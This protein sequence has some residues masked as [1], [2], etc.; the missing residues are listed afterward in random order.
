MNLENEIPKGT[1]V[2]EDEVVLPGIVDAQVHFRDKSEASKATL[3]SESIAALAG[4]VTSVINNPNQKQDPITTVKDHNE[5]LEKAKKESR[6][7]FSSN[8]LTTGHNLE[9]LLN[10]D[11]RFTP[12]FKSFVTQGSTGGHGT[13]FAAMDGIFA[14]AN[15]LSREMLVIVHSEDD[16]VIIPLEALAKRVYKN[17]E[18]PFWLNASIRNDMACLSSTL[19]VLDSRKRTNGNFH[20]YHVSTGIEC[21]LL[22]HQYSGS[23]KISAET[24]VHY[25]IFNDEAYDKLGAYAKCFPSIKHERDR[26]MLI[27]AVLDDVIS[28]I[29][30]DHAPHLEENK[31]G[32]YFNT[33]GGLPLVQHSLVSMVDLFSEV[34]K[35]DTDLMLSLIERKMARAPAERF[36]MVGRGKLEE[37][38]F[39]DITTLSLNNPWQ[40]S[41]SNILYKC[42][43]SPFEGHTFRAKVNNTFVNGSHSYN[44]GIF[45]HNIRGDL[46]EF[47]RN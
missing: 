2:I 41:K 36:K 24:C 1:I 28:M 34:L 16:E 29:T 31:Q 5:F 44:R 20:L 8:V 40:V 9:E 46:I 13:P 33:F 12:A 25:L 15:Q 38:Y 3:E 22:R 6:I 19:K 17:Q 10:L 43:Y 23:P 18:A 7:N 32:D 26:L 30:T 47:D 35:G 39:A 4:G 14:V 42:G 21:D 27:Q 11:P 37:G 45:D